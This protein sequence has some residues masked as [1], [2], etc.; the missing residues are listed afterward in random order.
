[1]RNSSLNGE[2]K[3]RLKILNKIGTGATSIVY[4]AQS[5]PNNSNSAHELLN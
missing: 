5:M 4:N 1:M 2:M 3:N